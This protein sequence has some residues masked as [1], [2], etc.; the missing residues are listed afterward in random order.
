M[1]CDFRSV[2]RAPELLR[3]LVAGPIQLRLKVFDTSG[4][5]DGPPAISE[6]ST[7]L[8]HHGRYGERKEIGPVVDVV[9]VDG[10]NQTKARSLDE[11][12]KR[13]AAVTE[14]PRD[15]ISERQAALNDLGALTRNESD[16]SSSDFKRRN[17]SVSSVYSGSSHDTRSP[18][19]AG[20]M[21]LGAEPPRPYTPAG[22][23]LKQTN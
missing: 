20:I 17:M 13:L 3:Q 2:R 1:F 6:V 4:Y 5:F 18:R 7:D 19:S 16:P 22:H 8:A 12:V 10:P 14:P 11:I 23:S 15:V 21:R 9:A